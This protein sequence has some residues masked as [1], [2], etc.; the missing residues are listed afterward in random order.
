[1]LGFCF[2]KIATRDTLVLRVVREQ[3]FFGSGSACGS[4]IFKIFG[5]GSCDA[6][7]QFFGSRS[8]MLHFSHAI[9]LDQPF[10]CTRPNR[11]IC[12]EPIGRRIDSILRTGTNRKYHGTAPYW[13]HELCDW[14]SSC[15]RCVT[16]LFCP[17]LSLREIYR[18]EP[19]LLERYSLRRNTM[20]PFII[21]LIAPCFVSFMIGA[22]RTDM[23]KIYHLE[24][25][26]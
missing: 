22:A 26:Q 5:C 16:A 20:V 24:G 15:S 3:V 25:T 6:P 14:G 13:K 23:R 7:Y 17:C 19:F 4:R 2:T 12:R 9:Y 1:M 10:T 11:I 18:E 21:S 8:A